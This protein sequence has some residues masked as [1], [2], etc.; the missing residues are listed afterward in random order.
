M[1]I[2]NNRKSAVNIDLEDQI[3][4]SQNSEIIV[5]AVE[6][7]KGI[8]NKDDGKVSWKFLIPPG[9]SQKVIYTYTIKY[10]KNRTVDT[11]KTLKKV[12]AR[13]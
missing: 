13:F 2:K 5:D 3:P 7:S 4:I 9:E 6:L 1:I 8:V 10:P 11:E 12:R